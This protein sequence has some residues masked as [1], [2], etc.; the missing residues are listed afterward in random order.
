[1]GASGTSR[2]EGAP[3]IWIVAVLAALVLVA[4][5]AA[6]LASRSGGF[7]RILAQVIAVVIGSLAGAL[8][9]F[10]IPLAPVARDAIGDAF[11]AGLLAT[12][13]TL[14]GMSLVE[15]LMARLDRR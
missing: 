6:L 14:V 3:A 10:V 1:M 5:A 13:G 7:V 15:M 11:W 9:G 8:A 12:F 2:I 4:G